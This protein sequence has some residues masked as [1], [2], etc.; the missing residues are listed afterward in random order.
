MAYDRDPVIIQ[1]LLAIRH[2]LFDFAKELISSGLDSEEMPIFLA[3]RPLIEAAHPG[4]E[5][6]LKYLLTK[7]HDVNWKSP[8]GNTALMRAAASHAGPQTIQL[9]LLPNA[10]ADATDSH[11]WIASMYA[12]RLNAV[13]VTAMILKAT[14]HT[15]V[16]G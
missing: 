9:L 5:E 15:Q 3:Q 10:H 4:H 1:L 8:D 11:G 14:A 13:E 12:A 7:V 6:M 16:A 2:G